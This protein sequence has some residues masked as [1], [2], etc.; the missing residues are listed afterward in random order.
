MPSGWSAPVA[1]WI[2]LLTA[3]TPVVDLCS[4]APAQALAVQVQIRSPDL[5]LARAIRAP[6]P[7]LPG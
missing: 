1:E 5:C 4:R 3:M 6:P 7:A 2:G